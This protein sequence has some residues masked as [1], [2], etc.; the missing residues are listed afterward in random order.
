[1][2]QLKNTGLPLGLEAHT[3]FEQGTVRLK[4]G[5]FILFYTDGITEASNAR[6]HFFETERLQKVLMD[7]RSAPSEDIVEALASAVDK[8]TAPGSLSDDL[9]MMVVKRL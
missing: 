7:F 3:I 8:F 4:P 9:T 2:I 6:G 5:D 1:M